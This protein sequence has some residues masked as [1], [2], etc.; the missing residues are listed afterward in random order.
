MKLRDIVNQKIRKNSVQFNRS[1]NVDLNI[2]NSSN[3]KISKKRYS[4]SPRKN[5]QDKYSSSIPNENNNNNESNFNKFA[6]RGSLKHISMKTVNRN[7]YQFDQPFQTN[8]QEVKKTT[9]QRKSVEF[10]D[11]KTKKLFQRYSLEDKRKIVSNNINK[12]SNSNNN[13]IKKTESFYGPSINK[14]ENNIKTVLYNMKLQFEKQKDVT[15]SEIN[16]INIID[17]LKIGRAHV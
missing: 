11:G 2:F 1:S 12:N 16:D 17:H 14:L 13:K 4:I 9:T 3:V 7:K 15:E 5:L 6:K 10:M 8:I